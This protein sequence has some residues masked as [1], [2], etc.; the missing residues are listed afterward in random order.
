MKTYEVQVRIEGT[1]DVEDPNCPSGLRGSGCYMTACKCWQDVTVTL[2]A[3]SEDEA[4]NKVKAHDF[5]EPCCDVEDIEK[6]EIV[7]VEDCG[8]SD[9]ECFETC[10]GAVESDEDDGPDPDDY[11]EERRERERS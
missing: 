8:E 1:I 5:E 9:E 7:S 6:V 4:R 2:T 10:W 3:D 11:Y